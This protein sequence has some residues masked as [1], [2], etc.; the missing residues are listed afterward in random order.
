MITVDSE[1]FRVLA[2]GFLALPPKVRHQVFGR[3]MGRSRGVVERTYARLSSARIDVAQKHIK[4]RMRSWASDDEMV[5]AIKSAQIPL[6]ELGPR[7]TG[8]GVSVPLRGSYRSAWIA[9]TKGG[10]VLKRVPGA[11]RYPVRML[12][13]PNPAGEAT[14]NPRVYEQMLGEI[15]SATFWREIAGGIDGML[16][17]L[18]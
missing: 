9:A 2:R 4:R 5:L 12:F 16:R 8:R 17:R 6:H 7:Q 1:E 13:G 18:G 15:A 3:A 14:R 10:K 11:D